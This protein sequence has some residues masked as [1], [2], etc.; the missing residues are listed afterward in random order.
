MKYCNLW[1]S[2]P[3]KWRR[4]FNDE[5]NDYW[6]K[7]Y[8][9]TGD[10]FDPAKRPDGDDDDDD[11]NGHQVVWLKNIDAL[12]QLTPPSFDPQNYSLID[13]GCGNG[14]ALTYF[15]HH[16]QFESF[17]GIEIS[18]TTFEACLE[19]IDSYATKSQRDI[20]N[21]KISCANAREFVVA[22]RKHMIFMYN[23][24]GYTTAKIFFDRNSDQLCRHGSYLALCNHIWSDEMQKRNDVSLCSHDPTNNLS[25]WRF[26]NK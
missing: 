14:V 13:I 18:K 7:K 1:H 11:F 8:C 20:T 17:L 19:N 10:I 15:L 22:N 25:L 23:P 24:F 26:G 4:K 6:V 2:E 3:F 5:F 21:V 16:F 12:M 9:L